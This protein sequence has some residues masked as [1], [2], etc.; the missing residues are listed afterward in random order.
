MP[1]IILTRG[2]PA[3]G[4]TTWSKELVANSNGKIIRISKDDLRLMFCETRKRE[5]QVIELRNILT[6][7]YLSDGKDVIWEDTNLN[8]I[9]E[10]IAKEIA[11]EFEATVEIK[12]FDTSLEECIVRDNKRLNGVG[13]KVITQMYNQYLR[14]PARQYTPQDNTIN[15]VIVDLDGTVAIMNGR[16]PFE[17][18]KVGEDLPSNPIIELVLKLKADG[19]NIVF[20]SGRSQVCREL[21][22]GWLKMYIK[23]DEYTLYMR[24]EKDM[25]PD[26]IVKKEILDNDLN[27]KFNIK[28]VL[29]DRNSVVQMWRDEGLTVLQVNDGDF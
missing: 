29:D 19:L 14:P 12:N 4:K 8:P 7:K 27:S 20:V 16:G 22:L 3:S 26:T 15:T 21:T 10:L 6:L 24:K 9:H 28:Y 23:L 18:L 2:L 17:W 13:S 1:K 5:G 25:R 11:S